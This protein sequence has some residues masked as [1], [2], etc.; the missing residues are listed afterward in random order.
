VAKILSGS[1]YLLLAGLALMAGGG[2]LLYLGHGHH[3][4]I[5]LVPGGVTV[6]HTIRF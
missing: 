2:T 3:T 6:R 1:K 4:A 5:G